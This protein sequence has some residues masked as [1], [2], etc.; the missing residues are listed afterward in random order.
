VTTPAVAKLVKDNQAALAL[1]HMHK[2]AIV[3]KGEIQ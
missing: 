1:E 3:P 2:V